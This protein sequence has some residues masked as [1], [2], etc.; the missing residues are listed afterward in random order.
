MEITTKEIKELRDA[1][2]ISVM[3]CKKA[4][5][6]V[7]GDLEKALIILRKKSSEIADKKSD[8]TLGAGVVSSYTHGTGKVGAMVTLLCETDFV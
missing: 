6:E 1:T 4:L 2:G 3:Q 5:E 7:G 8:R